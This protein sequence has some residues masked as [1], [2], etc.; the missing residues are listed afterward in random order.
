LQP[1]KL[2]E[3]SPKPEGFGDALFMSPY[4][5]ILRES[6]NGLAAFLSHLNNE[7]GLALVLSHLQT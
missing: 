7:P 3:Q 4:I 5:V 6:G 1:K 2:P